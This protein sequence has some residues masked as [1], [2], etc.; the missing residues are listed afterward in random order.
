MQK[1]GTPETLE[2]TISKIN[3]DNQQKLLQEN[4]SLKQQ[5]RFFMAENE[6]LRINQERI[7]HSQVDQQ[8]LPS[9]HVPFCQTISKITE[10]LSTLKQ[11]YE[12]KHKLCQALETENECY[13]SSCNESDQ[14][15]VLTR[16]LE[17]YKKIIDKLKL[18][19]SK[20]HHTAAS[21]SNYSSPVGIPSDDLPQPADDQKYLDLLEK[22]SESESNANNWKMEFER[23]QHENQNLERKLDEL[24]SLQDIHKMQIKTFQ[25]DFNDER[26]DKQN[27]L[28]ELDEWRNRFHG[29]GTSNR[30]DRSRLPSN[31]NNNNHQEQQRYPQS[32]DTGRLHI[33]FS[34][35]GN[36]SNNNN[37]AYDDQQP[38]LRSQSAIINYS[39]GGDGSLRPTS[40]NDMHFHPHHS[41]RPGSPFQNGNDGYS[42]QPNRRGSRSPLPSPRSLSPH[43]HVYPQVYPDGNFEPVQMAES[44]CNAEI[45]P[46]RSA[47][48]SHHYLRCSSPSHQHHH[49]D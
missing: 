20:L 6:R 41:N 43:R 38:R 47:S 33:G 24:K 22:V 7:S 9:E 10:E 37:H 36:N 45:P 49:Q 8:I 13:K 42:T 4:N 11:Q 26:T 15:P 2:E 27:L 35:G 14:V 25:D 17:A 30:V 48:P 18:E 34:V 1:P 28:K 44:P 23:L 5:N 31:N 3:R 19:N 29:A 16:R 32:N 21:A 12:E 46:V 39:S 40:A